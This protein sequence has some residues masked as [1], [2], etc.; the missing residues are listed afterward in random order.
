MLR[1]LQRL[2]PLG[3]VC[4]DIINKFIMSHF[5]WRGYGSC[6]GNVLLERNPTRT[7]TDF[8]LMLYGLSLEFRSSKIKS[9]FTGSAVALYCVKAHR[10]S[11]W[12]SPN[13]NPPPVKFT[14]IKF[15]RSNS[16]HV[17]TSRTSTPVP[18]F[19]AISLRGAF[20]QI[21]EILRFGDCFVVLSCPGYSFF[22]ATSP[23]L[24]PWTNFNHLW[25]K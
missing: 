19:I 24:N 5:T 2:E 14:P 6:F 1:W 17:T 22:L 11:Q 7:K 16:A 21:C 3:H 10:Q 25:L 4:L 15:L 12:R 13:F 8:D 18:N 23:R 20:S 9:L